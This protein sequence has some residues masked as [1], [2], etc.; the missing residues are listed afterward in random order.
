MNISKVPFFLSVP[1]A[2]E[3]VPDEVVWLKGLPETLLMCDVDRY[4]D[5]L[6]APAAEK[7]GLTIVITDVHRYVVD[8]NRLPGDIDEDSVLGSKNPRGKFTTGFHWVQTTT[9]ARLIKEPMPQALHDK[10]V[11]QYYLPFHKRIVEQFAELKKAGFRNVY[12]IDAHSMPSKGTAAHRDPGATRPQIVVSDQD[13]VSCESWFKD[14]VIEA[15]KSAG[16]EVG[17]NW[18]YK[19]GRITE[20]YGQPQK[21]QHTVQ[22]EMNRSVYMNEVTKQKKPELFIDVEKRVFRALATIIEKISEKTSS[23]N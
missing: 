15:Y 22:V 5:Q 10:L 13:G 14:V 6:Y 9:G 11:D 4:V 2:G 23:K 21:G 19:G 1:H 12:H 16:F 8:P 18:P 20:T 7:L 3:R 17:Y